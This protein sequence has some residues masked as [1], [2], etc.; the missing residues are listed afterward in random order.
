[1]LVERVADDADGRLR[2]EGRAAHQAPEVDGSVTVLGRSAAVGEI[3]T[4]RVVGSEGV[5]LVAEAVRA[6]CSAGPG[7][8][9][10][11]VASGV[12]G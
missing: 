11:P 2:L 7:E 1:M 4:A 8:P 9:G 6:G 3:V 10:S 5:D 12:A